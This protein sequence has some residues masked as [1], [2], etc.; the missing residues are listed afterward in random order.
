MAEDIQEQ[1][2][3]E[4]KAETPEDFIARLQGACAT[5]P[6]VAVYTQ[7]DKLM[8][9][10]AERGARLAEVLKDTHDSF[11]IQPTAIFRVPLD[12]LVKSDDEQIAIVQER[13]RRDG[14]DGAG[15]MLE[16]S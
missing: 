5:S 2:V 4:P 8:G 9:L 11:P 10:H 15:L 1:I 16:H 7:H 3:T 14:T 13:L 12:F 6:C